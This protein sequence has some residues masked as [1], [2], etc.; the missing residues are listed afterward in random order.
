MEARTVIVRAYTLNVNVGHAPCW[1]YDEAKRCEVLTLANCKPRIRDVA[2][3]DE[4]IAGVTPTRMGLRLAYLMQVNRRVLRQEYWKTYKGTRLDSIYKPRPQ[5]G[6]DRF[7]NP[8]HT[9]AESYQ[10]DLSSNII[11]WSNRF[12][13]FANSYTSQST[14][15][16][17]LRIHRKYSVLERGGMRAYGHIIELPD[18]FLEWIDLQT[19]LHLEEFQVLG[20]SGVGGCDCCGRNRSK[21]T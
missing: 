20:K 18:D 6:W 14:E 15:P 9:D 3:R 8:W 17:G 2:D 1:M 10:R 11:L 4:W 12:Y 7:E 5:G 19:T 13:V 21:S 16:Q